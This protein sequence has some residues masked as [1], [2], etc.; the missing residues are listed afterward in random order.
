VLCPWRVA[1]AAAARGIAED[2]PARAEKPERPWRYGI[3][4]WLRRPDGAVWLR[5]RPENGLLGGMIEIP[6]TP[7][8]GEP[9]TLAE[10]AAAAPAQAQWSLLPGTVRHG[11]TH[12][13]LELA[14]AAGD[15]QEAPSGLWSPV[16]GLGEHALP[17]LMKKVARHATS[18]LAMGAHD[19]RS[20]S[21]NSPA[22]A[23]RTGAK[24]RR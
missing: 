9:W 8:R 10:A 4:F 2:L 15:G 19:T 6:S 21:A 7:W 24:E 5:R 11:F 22:S 18:A 1:C 13:Q 16:A 23:R 17:T 14:V 20:N 3:A 12:F